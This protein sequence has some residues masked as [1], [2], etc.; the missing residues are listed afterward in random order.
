MNKQTVAIFALVIAQI[1]WGASYLLSDQALKVFPPATLTSIRIFIAAC[2]LGI[3]GLSTG[4]L[5]LIKLKDYKYFLLAAFCEPFVYFLCEA[6]SLTRVSP[7]VASVMLSFIPLLTPVFAFLIIRERVTLMNVIG[8]V[9]SVIGVLM[10]I[11]DK[12]GKL[13][14]DFIGL[15]LLFIGVL[16]SISYTLI[17]RKIPDGYNI[18]TI[19]FFMFCTSLLFFIPTALI[20]EW[21]TITNIDISSP[22]TVRAFWFIVGLALSSSCIAFLFFSFGVRAIGATRANVFNNIQPGVTAILAWLLLGDA[23]AWIKWL[24]IVVVVI[25]MFVSQMDIDK[26]KGDFKS[27]R[28]N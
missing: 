23:L 19:V 24:G 28:I 27:K 6:E 17:L 12:D 8:I 9:V 2:V 25:G 26:I 20:R 7:T 5:K 3:I 15:I 11:L 10:I 13:A 1:F 4:Q 16:A 18:I 21:G 14:I 22:D